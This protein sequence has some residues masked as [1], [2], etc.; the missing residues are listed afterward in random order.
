MTIDRTLLRWCRTEALA[1]LAR[2]LGVELPAIPDYGFGR[3]GWIRAAARRIAAVT[4]PPPAQD[5]AP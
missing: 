1:R 3:D 5:G 2:A 4:D